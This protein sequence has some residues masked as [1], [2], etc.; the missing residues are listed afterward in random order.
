MQ[1]MVGV[2]TGLGPL[3]LVIVL[4]GLGVWSSRAAHAPSTLRALYG[5]A[6]P[7][8]LGAAHT[9]LVLVDFQDEFVHGGLPLPGVHGAIARATELA[10]WARRSGILVVLV[11]NVSDR[12]AS[13]LFRRGVPTTAFVPGI[14]PQAGD[15]VVEKSMVGAFS[16]TDLDAQLRS[17]GVETLI[18][19]GVM[20]HLA[21]FSTASDATVLGYRVVVAADATA[22]RALPGA[23]G[24][25]G[26]DGGTLQRAALAA[27][28]DRVADVMLTRTIVALPVTR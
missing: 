27:M 13:P 10:A 8:S 12:P 11:R 28:A 1:T 6:P 19:A 21:V 18:V 4:V 20:T 23:G 17:R 16:R 15:L 3:A 25:D 9:A 2:K 7:V 24:E 5:L 22:T 26:V 14:G